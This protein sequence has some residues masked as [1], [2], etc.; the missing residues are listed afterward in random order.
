MIKDNFN[1]IDTDDNKSVNDCVICIDNISLSDENLIKLECGH[2][3]HKKCIDTWVNDN[4]NCP[5]CR[6]VTNYK[7][8]KIIEKEDIIINENENEN[9]YLKIIIIMEIIFIFI[10]LVL[11]IVNIMLL[12]KIYNFINQNY[13]ENNNN[14]TSNSS[15]CITITNNDR[16]NIYKN[17]IRYD[18][19]IYILFIF[20]M[21][22]TFIT[23]LIALGKKTYIYVIFQIIPFFLYYGCFLKMYLK[24]FE[25]LNIMKDILYCENISNKIIENEKLGK[26]LFWSISISYL[27]FNILLLYCHLKNKINR[28]RPN[29]NNQI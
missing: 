19:D 29:E 7:S 16:N 2:Y 25:Y 21:L 18:Y 5:I 9:K 28:I 20:Y 1:V 4:F 3:Y 6:S 23:P 22:Y 24:I 27:V 10:I 12:P 15:I 26:Y 17:T 14:E 8:K 11:N 13:I